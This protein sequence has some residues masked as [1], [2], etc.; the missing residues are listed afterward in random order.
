MFMNARKGLRGD[1]AG[2]IY[3]GFTGSKCLTFWYFMR[4]SGVRLLEVWVD[5]DDVL[6]LDGSQGNA[7]KKAE[8]DI[9]G[10][11]SMVSIYL[12]W[13]LIHLLMTQSLRKP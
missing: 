13:R 6:L 11:D 1:D 4:G 5:D 8:L 2:L 9:T 12:R 3:E 7:W 10:K